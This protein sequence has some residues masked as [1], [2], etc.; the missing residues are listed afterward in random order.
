MLDV[1]L[2]RTPFGDCRIGPD[3]F[4]PLCLDHGTD[5]IIVCQGLECL[6]ISDLH[7]KDLIFSEQILALILKDL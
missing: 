7:G 4:W 6:Q 2:I 5:R 1:R 3:V